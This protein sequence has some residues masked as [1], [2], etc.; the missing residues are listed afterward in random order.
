MV[1]PEEE[2]LPEDDVEPPLDDDAWEPPPLPEDP[3]ARSDRLQARAQD[4]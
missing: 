1:P 2:P 3:Q 4:R